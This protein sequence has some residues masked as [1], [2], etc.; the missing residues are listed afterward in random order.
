[1]AALLVAALPLAA[2]QDKATL[3]RSRVEMITLEG[4]KFEVRM[5]ATDV[6]GEYRLLVVRGTMVINPDPEFEYQRTWVVARQVMDRTCKG[7]PYV[8]L[9]D[10]LID[11]VNLQTRFR[12]QS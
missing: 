3:D 4:R 1:M 7:K 5:A 12:C 11:S 9:D 10:N 6:P 8:T 2:C